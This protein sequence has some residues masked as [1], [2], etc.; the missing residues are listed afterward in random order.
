MF[1]FLLLNKLIRSIKLKKLQK[2]I[3]KHQSRNL[4]TQRT[5]AD[6]AKTEWQK[7]GFIG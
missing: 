3:R 1:L 7:F 2:I 4:A 5:A 6:K